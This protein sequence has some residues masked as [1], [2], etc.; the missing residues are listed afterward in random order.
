MERKEIKINL[1]TF[2]C[3]IIIV[4]LIVAVVGMYMLN[5]EEKVNGDNGNVSPNVQ[6]S[7]NNSDKGISFEK[8]MDTLYL[9]GTFYK[10]SREY[11]R[12]IGDYIAKTNT[13]VDEFNTI[14][15]NTTTSVYVSYSDNKIVLEEVVYDNLTNGV[16]RNEE[17]TITGISEEVVDIIM[18]PY[19]GDVRPM[20]IVFL[21]REGN[22]YVSEA[23]FDN[24]FSAR[25]VPN[26]SKV[27]GIV[28]YDC[29]GETDL[30]WSP[31]ILALK[32]DGT[33]E[34]IDWGR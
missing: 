23:P 24:N 17:Y 29:V 31:V 6:L 33:N 20:V 13:D 25:K 9:P 5:K 22:V 12:N 32:Y 19:E 28:Y 8:L 15:T 10:N 27:I 11:S 14:T 34:R 4:I 2:V 7:D 30:E 1:A 3:L 18:L 26:L 16:I 21:T